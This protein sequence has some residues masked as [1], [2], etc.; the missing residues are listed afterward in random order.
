MNEPRYYFAT[1]KIREVTI[2]G[3]RYQLVEIIMYQPSETYDREF[4]RQNRF[5]T[6]QVNSDWRNRLLIDFLPSGT[7][8]GAMAN[9]DLCFRISEIIQRHGG[10]Y[11]KPEC[12]AEIK[13]LLDQ[14]KEEKQ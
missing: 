9:R 3:Q 12:W 8:E 11:Q 1:R 2:C 7:E 5:G 10:Q 14:S 13:A 6:I 4:E